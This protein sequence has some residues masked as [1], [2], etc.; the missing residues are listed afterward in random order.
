MGLGEFLKRPQ[1]WANP[2][3]MDAKFHEDFMHLRETEMLARDEFIKHLE[4]DFVNGLH[5]STQGKIL[6]ENK[7]IGA[8]EYVVLRPISKRKVTLVCLKKIGKFG[9]K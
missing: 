9:G 1:S 6:Y 4:T 8:F 2:E 5:V 3:V 7:K